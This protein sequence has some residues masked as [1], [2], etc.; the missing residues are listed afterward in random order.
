[1]GGASDVRFLREMLVQAAYR[2]EVGRPS[3]EEMLAS[4]EIARYVAGWGRPG[5][6]AVIA[7]DLRARRLGAAWYRLFS[8]DEPGF[9]FIDTLTPEISIALLPDQR[10]RGIGSR[11]LEALIERARREGFSAL[12]LSVSPE[13]PAADLYRRFGFVRVRSGDE[14]W[15]MRLDLGKTPRGAAASGGS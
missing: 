3:V 11:L 14:H 10:G 1:M 7:V 12:S 15:T 8:S 4:R 6:A 2:P 13:N 5:D 9:G